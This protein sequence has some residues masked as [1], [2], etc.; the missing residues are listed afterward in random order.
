MSDKGEKISKIAERLLFFFGDPNLRSDRFMQKALEREDDFGASLDATKLLNF[1]SIKQ[2]TGE[3]E[4]VIDA[5]RTLTDFLVVNENN[6]ISRKVPMKKSQ[7]DDNIPLSLHVSNLPVE[8]QKYAVGVADIKALFETY[9]NVTLTRLKWKPAVKT[10][11]DEEK[12]SKN[13]RKMEPTGAC[14]VEFEKPDELDKAAA[15]LIPE[16]KDEKKTLTLKG[17]ELQIIK[18]SDYIDARKMSKQ[19]NYKKD[20]GDSSECDTATGN[21]NNDEKKRKEPPLAVEKFEIDWKPGCV[22]ELKGLDKEKCDRESIKAAIEIEDNSIYADYSRGQ[23]DGAVRFSK[24]CVEIKEIAEK[25]NSGEIKIAESKV[26]TARVLEGEEEQTYWKT[27]IDFKNKKL[28]LR[29]EEA[30]KKNKRRR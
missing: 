30:N 9:G 29:A 10:G 6:E 21:I 15:D 24:P 23:T 18:L 19:K 4:T 8:N 14:V 3:I 22:I 20:K 11:N 7:L 26:E 12:D 2:H 1:H 25:L 28:Q 27:F 13:R 17:E 5:A 16:D